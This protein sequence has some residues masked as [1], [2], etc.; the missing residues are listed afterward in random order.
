MTS[1]EA[2]FV[3]QALESGL[4][5]AQ[6]VFLFNRAAEH[7]KTASMFNKLA[8][9]HQDHTP[10]AL[11]S[12]KSLMEQEVINRRYSGKKRKISIS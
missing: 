2:G 7:P 3:K 8:D 10:N 6:A 9:S 4:T 11:A 12:L 5:E 1:F